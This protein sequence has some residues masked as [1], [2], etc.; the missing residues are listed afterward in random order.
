VAP[1]FRPLAA[2][3]RARGQRAKVPAKRVAL[4]TN[5]NNALQYFSEVKCEMTDFPCAGDCQISMTLF[6]AIPATVALRVS[7][8]APWLQFP[9][10]TACRDCYVIADLVTNRRLIYLSI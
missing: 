6:T 4:I 3:G 1:E 10:E 8:C 7:G 2:I 9:A 5:E